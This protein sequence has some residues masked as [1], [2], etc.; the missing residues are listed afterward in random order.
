MLVRRKRGS[1][2]DLYK[3]QYDT[4]ED[5]LTAL[6]QSEPIDVDEYLNN[7]VRQTFDVLWS[8][9]CLSCDRNNPIYR[10][11]CNACDIALDV[12]K[13]RKFFP[14]NYN[15]YILGSILNAHRKITSVIGNYITY[16]QFVNN[17]NEIISIFE[18]IIK[19][20][21]VME[22]RLIGNV[23]HYNKAFKALVKDSS[24][25]I[26]PFL[27]VRRSMFKIVE[28]A[29]NKKRIFASDAYVKRIYDDEVPYDDKEKMLRKLEKYTYDYLI[30]KK[31]LHLIDE[32]IQYKDKVHFSS[33]YRD[34]TPAPKVVYALD[35]IAEDVIDSIFRDALYDDDEDE[36]GEDED[37]DVDEDEDEDKDGDEE[38]DEDEE[39]D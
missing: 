17:I 35:D 18:N 19:I 32:D 34:N 6:K 39:G 3:N 24:D 21:D 16:S 27:N 20:I 30:N 38:G 12:K 23:I 22:Y 25:N 4:T 26:K 1:V 9:Q 7:T 31:H 8:D 15:L 36:D 28:Y 29:I 2:L 33:I 14:H 10:F 5:W 37:E 13:G 11:L